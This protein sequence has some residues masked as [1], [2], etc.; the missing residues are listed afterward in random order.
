MAVVG[1]V[2]GAI[3]TLEATTAGY[4]VAV[5]SLGINLMGDLLNVTMRSWRTLIGVPIGGGMLACS[6]SC[7][8]RRGS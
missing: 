5:G 4:R 2:H 1:G 6:M 3:K 8:V 7:R